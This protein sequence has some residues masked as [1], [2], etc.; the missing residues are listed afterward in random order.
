MH[1]EKLVELIQETRQ[2]AVDTY[3]AEQRTCTLGQAGRVAQQAAQIG[4]EAVADAVFALMTEQDHRIATL[5][6]NLDVQRTG[7]MTAEAKLSEE[8]YGRALAEEQVRRWIE[9]NDAWATKA[10]ALERVQEN[11]IA[12]EAAVWSAAADIVHSEARWQW[13][14][15]MRGVD[16]AQVIAERMMVIESIL[17][18]R[19]ER[20]EESYLGLPSESWNPQ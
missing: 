14:Q 10:K 8:I 1:R 19:S 4:D 5:E 2:N 6:N 13:E 20:E 18:H 17:R 11:A 9:S 15:K 3:W 16:F 7:R 12:H